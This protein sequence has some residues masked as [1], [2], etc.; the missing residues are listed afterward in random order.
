LAG[1]HEV[2]L[3]QECRGLGEGFLGGSRGRHAHRPPAG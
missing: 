3:Q 2:T 1:L